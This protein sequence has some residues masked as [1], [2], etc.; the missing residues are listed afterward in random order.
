M[1]LP[2][3]LKGRKASEVFSDYF[4]PMLTHWLMNKKLFQQVGREN[5]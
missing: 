5:F 1:K 3:E 2:P 4:E